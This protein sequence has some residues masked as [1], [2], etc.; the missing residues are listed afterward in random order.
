MLKKK[1]GNLSQVAEALEV[2]RTAIYDWLQKDEEFKTA[3]GDQIE[4]LIDFAESTLLKSMQNGSDTATIFFLK[5]RAKKRG[6]IE[7]TEVE[8]SGS[9]ATPVII[10]WSGSDTV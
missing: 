9:I 1:A 2:S 8:H 3:H 10:D 6:Y 7:K 5:C 4:S